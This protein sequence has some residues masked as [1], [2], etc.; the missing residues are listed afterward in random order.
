MDPKWT[1]F[2]FNYSHDSS[3]SDCFFM[4]FLKKSVQNTKRGQSEFANEKQLRFYE[5]S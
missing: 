5:A 3:K 4:E 2:Y 1:S